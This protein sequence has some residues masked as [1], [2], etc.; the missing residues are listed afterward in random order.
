MA[1]AGAAVALVVAL[2][3]AADPVGENKLTANDPADGREFGYSVAVFGDTAVLGAVNQG[4]GSK[5]GSAYVFQR[6]GSTWS[7]KK[8]LT[9]DVGADGDFFGVSVALQG[10]TA[11]VGAQGLD[12]QTGAAF[13]FTGAGTDWTQQAKL[14]ADDPTVFSRLGQS[15][16]IDG[17]TVVVGAPAKASFRGA[18]YVFTRAGTTWTQQQKLVAADGAS[19]DQFGN[20]VAIEGDTILVG[21]FA[22]DLPQTTDVGAAY[23]FTRTGSVWTERKTLLADDG[24]AEDYFGVSVALSRGTALVGSQL[25]DV[26]LNTNQ[27][28]AYVF[29]GSGAD[30]TKEQKLLRTDGGSDESFGVF[31]AIEGDTALV[32]AMFADAVPPATGPGAASVFERAL[33][34]WTQTS[35]LFS[36]ETVDGDQF[37]ASLA[38]HD[39][40][41]IVGALGQSNL[42][43]AAYP[44]SGLPAAALQVTTRKGALTDST[45]AGKDAAAVT[46]NVAFRTK[47]DGAFDP[48]AETLRLSVG[49]STPLS[50][51]VPAG[52]AAWKTKVNAKKQTTTHTWKTAKGVKPKASV[53]LVVPPT[54]AATLTANVSALDLPA[55]AAAGFVRVTVELG[56]D[57]GGDADAWRKKKTKRVFP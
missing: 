56:A 34:T 9:P 8:K 16:A 3:V 24:A 43:G 4:A 28:A 37:G 11:V 36:N 46:C 48:S 6:T 30:W 5:Q 38:L 10:A 20:S 44:F 47:S 19:F 7:Q 17:D 12:D 33:G 25:H 31:V 39:G 23:V 53:K 21:A 29:T 42:T 49:G 2:R 13:V 51:L 32:G 18:V 55:G 54:G 15:V 1:T 50:L 22:R 35:E 26:G 41:A 52:D 27:G 45:K 40:T 57:T 14:T